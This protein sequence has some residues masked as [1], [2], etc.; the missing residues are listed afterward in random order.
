MSEIFS[1][2]NKQTNKQTNKTNMFIKDII[3][4][5]IDLNVSDG[6]LAYI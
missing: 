5:L 1:S 6:L 3:S 4:Q 2:T